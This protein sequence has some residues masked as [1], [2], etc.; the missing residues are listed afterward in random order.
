MLFIP[1]DKEEELLLSPTLN[2]LN[3]DMFKLSIEFLM[4]H[5]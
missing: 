1:S 4:D 5:L 2:L 3:K